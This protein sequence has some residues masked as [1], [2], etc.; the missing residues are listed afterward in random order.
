M[1]YKLCKYVTHAG[2]NYV[3]VENMVKDKSRKDGYSGICKKCAY[4]R[5]KAYVQRLRLGEN[6]LQTLTDFNRKQVL[7]NKQRKIRNGIENILFKSV[8]YRSIRK[9]IEFN[10]TIDDIVIPDK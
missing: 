8:R 5:K 1:K 7:R 3:N 2:D 9:N 4:E 6:K 10:L